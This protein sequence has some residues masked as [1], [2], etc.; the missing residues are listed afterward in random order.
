MFFIIMEEDLGCHSQET[1]SALL[2]F[3]GVEH[4]QLDFSLRSNVAYEP[5]SMVVQRMLFMQNPIQRLARS[6]VQSRQLRQYLRRQLMRFNA[7][8]SPP[9]GH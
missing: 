1:F 5:R 8:R 7:R 6:L 4:Q 9:P 3:L 2:D